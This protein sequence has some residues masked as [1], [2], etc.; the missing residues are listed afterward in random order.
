M[1]KIIIRQGQKEDAGDILAFS[2]EVGSQ[3]DNLSFG[4]EGFTINLEEE[5]EFL[6]KMQE[7]KTSIFYTAWRGEKLLGTGSLQ[8]FS[9][10]MSH[11]GEV[12]LAVLK[13]SWGLGIGSQLMEKIIAYGKESGL[14]LLN[15]EV[16]KDNQRAIRL[17]EKY[18]FKKL[19]RMPDFF[20]L[21]DR[22]VDFDYM[23][24]DLRK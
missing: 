3:T 5:K 10:R 14:E 1:D 19:G 23:Y 4:K 22:Y 7:A 15:L 20:K 17:Y 6:E 8:G 24:L 21:E 12:A 16:G 18:G 11:R 13:E 2:R 9:R